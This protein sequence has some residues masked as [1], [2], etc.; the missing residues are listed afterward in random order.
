MPDLVRQFPR[1]EPPP[2]SQVPS[3]PAQIYNVAYG[4]TM[5]ELEIAVNELIA[6]GWTP[7][8]GVSAVRFEGFYQATIKVDDL[9]WAAIVNQLAGGA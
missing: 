3:L 1:P 8:G 4:G 2:G 9:K 7:L 5:R 6:D